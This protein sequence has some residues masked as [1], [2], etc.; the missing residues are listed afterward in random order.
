M[1]RAETTRNRAS[2]GGATINIRTGKGEKPVPYI[3]KKMITLQRAKEPSHIFDV[4]EVI[5]L[6]L[7][8]RGPLCE[9]M[10]FL[11]S[12]LSSL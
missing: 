11:C 7:F 10:L 9:R 6:A 8:Y 5:F 3:H 4:K 2:N 1:Q 12:V